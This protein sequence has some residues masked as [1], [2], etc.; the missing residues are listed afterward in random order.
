MIAG[1]ATGVL[2]GLVAL[3][4]WERILRDQAIRAIPVRVHV[5]GTRGKSTVTR[6]IAA[7]LRASGCPTIA[8]TTGTAA[9]LILPDGTE[10][11][12]ARRTLPS[13]R[14]QL[15]LLREARRL[16]ARAL[17]VECMALVPE[18]Q[19][20]SEHEMVRATIGVLT[21]ARPDHADVMGPDTASVAE[22]LSNTV[23]RAATL[24]LGPDWKHEAPAIRARALSTTVIQ[25][26]RAD[27]LPFAASSVPAWMLD[28]LA[29]ALAVTRLLG[30]DDGVAWP[31]M[32]A[33]PS[34]P[35][36]LN[37]RRPRIGGR[38]VPF[39][40]GTAANDPESLATLLAEDGRDGRVFVFNHRADRALR[41]RQF[42]DAPL[43][44]EPGTTVLVT[45]DRCD[46]GTTRLL[47]R[48]LGRK[49]AFVP[50]RKLAVEVHERVVTDAAV[51]VV[52]VCGN[53]KHI[54]SAALAAALEAR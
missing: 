40:D 34:D 33:A 26:A 11:P 1:V 31:A 3:G 50:A 36:T 8:K 25:A 7:A 54:D 21:N 29:T 42:A 48:T 44:R 6:L 52:I 19:R 2:A 46:L 38:L 45:G 28:N 10:R 32:L 13:I 35:G 20:T 24:V 27:T 12:I 4:G 15:W 18:L 41:L 49:P 51:K 5:N 23:P 43:W 37:V 16:G 17:V 39:I 47:A 22:A 9:R 30:I 14:E 53:S